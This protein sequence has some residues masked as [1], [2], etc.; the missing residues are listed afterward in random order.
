MNRFSAFLAFLCCVISVNA[1][2]DEGPAMGKLLVATDEVQG[3]AFAETVILLLHYD[4]TGALGVVINRPMDATPKDVLPELDALAEYSGTL[5]WGGPVRMTVMRALMRSNTPPDDAVP[6][7]DTVYRV[8]LADKLP[9]NATDSESLRFFVGYAGWAPGQLDRELL[10]GS[11]YVIPA[12][13]EAV[14]A[15]EPDEIWLRLSPPRHYR[16]A[17][18]EINSG[19]RYNGG[20]EQGKKAKSVIRVSQSMVPRP[21]PTREL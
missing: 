6:V 9:G 2:A 21:V 3:P 17:T 13:E 5:Y 12:T 18:N 8:P 11:W 10:F 1:S 16:A 20:L 19:T 4:E 15:E 14:F 7:F